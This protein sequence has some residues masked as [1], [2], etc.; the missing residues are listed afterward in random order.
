MGVI[1]GVRKGRNMVG[2][3]GG[4]VGVGEGVESVSGGRVWWA[5]KEVRSYWW[6]E[7]RASL[8]GEEVGVDGLVELS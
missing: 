7:G 1:S 5:W 4:V 3:G 6:V 8:S 2:V